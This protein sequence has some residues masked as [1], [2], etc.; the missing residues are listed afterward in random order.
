[1]ETE[2]TKSSIA[3]QILE[4]SGLNFEV[5]KRPHYLRR[6][7]REGDHFEP[8]QLSS[9]I[10]R[11]DTG[12][13]IGD[14]KHTYEPAQNAEI[15]APFVQA[16]IDGHIKFVKGRA[17]DNGR[18]F[19]L[20][21]DTGENQI[22]GEDLKRRFIV[23]AAHD[24]TSSVKIKTFIWRQICRNGLMGFGLRDSFAVRH[25]QNWRAGYAQILRQLHQTDAFF[26][27]A[28][29][30]YGRLFEIKL[31]NDEKAKMTAEL[32]GIKSDEKPSTRKTN[33]ALDIL[34]IDR[35]R[36]KGLDQIRGT[37]ACW[38]N[39]V[40]EYYDNHQNRNNEEKQYVSAF[41]GQAES[42]KKKAFEMTAALV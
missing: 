30:R 28:I 3:T 13:E 14:V 27:T 19:A 39:A 21:F 8:S 26:E 11:T 7:T 10:I 12:E 15:V 32:V 25:T 29:Q 42:Q 38:F 5:E 40:I 41:F 20:T 17:I 1:M 4:E 16:A 23:S 35:Y 24:G 33:Q 37:A 36:G 2:T 22:N 34:T 31:S 9:A 18:F 6:I